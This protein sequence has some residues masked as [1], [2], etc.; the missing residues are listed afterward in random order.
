M[1]ESAKQGQAKV[2]YRPLEGEP[3]FAT[4]FDAALGKKIELRGQQGEIHFITS[5]MAADKKTT[6]N[7]LEY[8]SNKITGA[9]KSSMAAEG[10][11][12]TSA[13]DKQL[14]G[15]LLLR[16]L[17]YGDTTWSSSWRSNLKAPGILITGP[18]SLFDHCTKTGHMV[19]ERQTALD[20]LQVKELIQANAIILKWTPTFRQLAD[21]FTKEMEQ[22][23]I[24]GWKRDGGICLVCTKEDLKIEHIG[25][26]LERHN[27]KGGQ[28]E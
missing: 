24:R 22:Q 9:V 23:L 16:A 13:A 2:R 17:W 15:R 5:C 21:G 3:V 14:Y 18:K 8:H 1:K 25:R 4:Y 7:V 19:G 26:Q 27:E 6:A 11:S 28:L 20:V 10:C 12:M